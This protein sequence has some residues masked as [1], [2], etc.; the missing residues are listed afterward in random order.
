MQSLLSSLF[1]LADKGIGQGLNFLSPASLFS[2]FTF[3][4][5]NPF[6]WAPGV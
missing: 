1:L 6:C 5:P 3:Y 2:L 4:Q